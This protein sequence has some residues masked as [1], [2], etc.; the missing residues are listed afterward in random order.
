MTCSS[1][2]FL[3]IRHAC[4]PFSELPLCIQRESSRN[5]R[6]LWPAHKRV[7]VCVFFLYI[8]PEQ[9]SLAIIPSSSCTPLTSSCQNEALQIASSPSLHLECTYFS[10]STGLQT[11]LHFQ[12]ND[13]TQTFPACAFHSQSERNF[14][15]QRSVRT[16]NDTVTSNIFSNGAW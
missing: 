12:S 11:P 3:C 8:Y 16:Y 14:R 5:T 2:F 4:L 10:L 9:W 1:S 7:C 13:A 6:Q 15:E